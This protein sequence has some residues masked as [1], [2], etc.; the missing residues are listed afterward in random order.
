[1]KKLTF[2]IVIHPTKGH[3]SLINHEGGT[4]EILEVNLHP[5]ITQIRGYAIR[6]F[7]KFVKEN[8]FIER[9]WELIDETN[10]VIDVCSKCESMDV[11]LKCW[12]NGQDGNISMPDEAEEEDTWCL[13]CEA[14][15]GTIQKGG[16]FTLYDSEKNKRFIL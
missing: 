2:K 9:D 12:V 1:M 10:I 6:F 13:K 3:I 15:T 8:Y 4:L 7:K 14:H 5:E 16:S 11:D